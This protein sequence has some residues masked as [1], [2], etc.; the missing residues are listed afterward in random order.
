MYEKGLIDTIIFAIYWPIA[1]LRD[2][3]V[4]SALVNDAARGNENVSRLIND[5]KLRIW[6]AGNIVISV[7]RFLSDKAIDG[8]LDLIKWFYS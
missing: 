5:D 3:R 4:F 1:Q 2:N 7:N 8:F 6:L